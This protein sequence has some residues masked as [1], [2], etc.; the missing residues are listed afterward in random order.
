MAE[1][2]PEATAA[3]AQTQ[4]PEAT[5]ASTTP[6]L[7]PEDG[8]VFQIGPGVERAA[9]GRPYERRY[10]HEPIYRP[11]RIFAL[12]PSRS[13][14]EGS[15]ATLKIPY[16]P[17]EPGPVGSVFEVDNFDGHQR[18]RR[19]DLEDRFIL[20]SSGL[21]PNASD[22]RFHQQMVYAVASSVY[23]T[24][25]TALGRHL[26]WGFDEQPGRERARLRLKPHGFLDRN[27]HYDKAAGEIC[28]GYYRAPKEPVGRNLPN[29]WIFTCLSHDIIVHEVTHALLDGLRAHFTLP[30]GLDV[31]AFHEAFADLVAIFQR[32]SY[33]EVVRTA[34]SRS[35]GDLRQAKILT[36]I[37]SQ[38]GET[39]REDGQPLR[40]ALD[41]RHKT[42]DRPLRYSEAKNRYE[43]GSVLVSAVFDAFTTVFRRK[44]RRYLLL[45]TNGTGEFPPGELPATLVDLL[46]REASQLASQFLS[47]AIRAIDYCPPVDVTFGGYLRALITADRVLVPDDPWSYRE[48]L[49]DAFRI[50]GIYPEEVANLSEE[51]L[52]WRAPLREIPVFT[53]LTFAELK[54]QGDPS[55]AAGK[56]ELRRQ[57]CELGRAV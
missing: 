55:V 29:G 1:N 15:I 35:R 2:K 5:Q 10:E 46:A 18:N 31:L 19:V 33:E 44:T 43:R 40:S 22:P 6:Y 50:R 38:F 42:E 39:T 52:L 28:F 30:I 16:E 3:T 9:R 37:G 23:A 24:F 21:D 25:R 57:A 51:A 17:L 14:L 32:F 45:A 54:F 12:D 13:K 26:A 34:L 27:A 47:I 8:V 11:L 36:E 56:D 48:A 20:T 49:I 41:Q 53:H 4:V 7:C